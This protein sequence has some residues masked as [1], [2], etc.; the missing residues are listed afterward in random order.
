MGTRRRAEAGPGAGPDASALGVLEVPSGG[1]EGGGSSPDR[2]S[3]RPG[4]SLPR[5]RVDRP[6]SR[7]TFGS[8]GTAAS[9]GVREADGH[10]AGD[11]VA[12]GDPPKSLAQ[13]RRG[14]CV[15]RRPEA[16]RR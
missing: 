8:D 11:A 7:G 2:G 3:P 4:P 6:G 14:L 5:R 10:G 16:R 9:T 12:S 15:S 13:T 1:P